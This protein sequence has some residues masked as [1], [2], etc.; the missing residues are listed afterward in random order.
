MLFAALSPQ[1]RAASVA[2]P[3]VVALPYAGMSARVTPGLTYTITMTT[4]GTTAKGQPMNTTT[5]AHAQIA[6]DQLRMDWVAPPN[7]P[8]APVN[9]FMNIMG[10]GTYWIASKGASTLTIVDP[11]KKQYFTMNTGGMMQG[12]GAMMSQS[13]T[14]IDI[15]TKQIPGDSVID[16]LHTQH[17]Q[18][19]DNHTIKISILGMSMA[20]KVQSTTD[21]YFAPELK[22]AINPWVQSAKATV[23]A[24]T[25]GSEYMQ[26]LGA[27][28][29]QMYDGMPLLEI[30]HSTTID[31]KNNQSVMT[32]TRH[33]TNI[34]QGDVPASVFVIPPDY[35]QVQNMM[36]GGGGANGGGANGSPSSGNTADSSK[37]QT[38]GGVA[39]K[40][41]G[42]FRLP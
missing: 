5:M 20:S 25:G 41:L 11:S 15:S 24:N 28:T 19:S 1:L 32:Q 3:L 6:G 34:T 2:L 16:G 8:A 26:K 35:Q 18:L 36:A 30:T 23:Q 14:D 37:A 39:K 42:K 38:P 17:Y 27:A 33:I 13:I 7:A 40:A 29:A 10:P 22:G 21:Y 4:A 12:L 31:S 9:P